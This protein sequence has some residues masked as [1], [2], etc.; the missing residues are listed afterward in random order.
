MQLN[1][2][3][4]DFQA[5]KELK[6]EWITLLKKSPNSTCF[7]DYDWLFLW[8][9]Y[10]FENSYSLNILTIRKKEELIAILPLYLNKNTL[11]FLGTG[12]DEKD[13]VATEYLD[14]IYNPK[15][16]NDVL[17]KVASIFQEELSKGYNL[18]LQNYLETSLVKEVIDLNKVKFWDNTIIC[19]RRYLVP[20]PK[21]YDTY[22]KTLSRSFD[23]RMTRLIK[24]FENKLNG[25]IRKTKEIN[26]RLNP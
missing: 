16:K 9:I 12:G 6:G 23:K 14:I 11:M 4:I 26:Q 5:F 10:F 1:I 25:K 19:G 3:K 13:E 22:R 18:N 17:H 21:N 7:L 8:C 20:L 2:E 24:K 15:Y